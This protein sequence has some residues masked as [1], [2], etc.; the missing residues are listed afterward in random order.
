M[1]EEFIKANGLRFTVSRGG[2]E[3]DILNCDE[4]SAFAGEFVGIVGPNGAGKTTLLKALAGLIEAQGEIRIMDCSGKLRRIESFTGRER[5]RALCFMHQD[6]SVPFAFTVREVVSM[7][8]YPWQ[9]RFSSLSSVDG[10]IVDK[11]MEKAGCLPISERLV[12]SLSGGERQMVMLARALAQDTHIILLDEPTASL[13]IGNAQ[14]V[15]RI[16]RELAA[17]GNCVVAVLHDLRQAA[18]ACTRVCLLNS[19]SVL[20]SGS[21]KEV[22][23]PENIKSAYGVDVQVFENPA[24]EWDFYIN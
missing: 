21:P 16:C 6:T 4:F 15:F 1:A 5:S 20:S 14:N 17:A 9:G 19:G 8:R 13:D 10:E 3:Q 7:G 24:G 11:A 2:I 18:A 22:L 23:T 12:P